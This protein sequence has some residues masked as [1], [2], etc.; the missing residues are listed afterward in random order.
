MNPVHKKLPVL[1]HNGKP[2]CESLIQDEDIDETWPGK[3]ALIPSDFIKELR[4]SFGET[5][6]TKWYK[7]KH[8]NLA[9]TKDKTS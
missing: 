3:N 1:I 9:K 8:H 7:I 4:P 2:V 6:S 5:S